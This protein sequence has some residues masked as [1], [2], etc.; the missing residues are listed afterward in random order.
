MCLKIAP[1]DWYWNT[2]SNMNLHSPVTVSGKRG[3]RQGGR[4]KQ[5][6]DA[7]TNQDSPNIA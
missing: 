6:S 3:I 2:F 4:K 7:I 5:S 1:I